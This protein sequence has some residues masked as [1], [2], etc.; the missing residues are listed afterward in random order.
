[1][2]SNEDMITCYF[3][4]KKYQILA[5]RIESIW[6][7]VTLLIKKKSKQFVTGARNLSQVTFKFLQQ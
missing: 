7:H 6:E 3:E 5:R 2:K 4:G 1:M